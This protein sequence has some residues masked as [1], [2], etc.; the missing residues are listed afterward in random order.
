[1]AVDQSSRS[2]ELEQFYERIEA[3]SLDALWRHHGPGAPSESDACAPYAAHFWRWSDI[4][5]FMQRAGELIA[6]SHED[7]R[8]ALRLVHPS[9]GG[10]RGSATH[11][12]SAA[13]QMVLPGEVAPAHRHTMAAIRFIIKGEGTVTFVDGEPCA[14]HPGDLI[15]TPGWTWHAHLNQTGEPMIW[16]DSLDSPLIG[17]LRQ[18][19]YEEY[20]D[21]VHPATR[22]V[23][24]SLDRYGGGHLRPVWERHGAPISPLLS[25]PWE[26]TER[27]LSEMAR[28]GEASPY[29][30]VAFQYTNPATGGHVLPTIGCWI[31]LIR[32]GIQTQAHRHSSASIYHVFRG[33]GA[34]IIDGARLDWEQGDFFALPPYCWHEHLSVG[35]DGAVLFSTNDLP[36]VTA[37]NL[38]REHPYQE[39]GGHQPV[40][41][42]FEER[43]AAVRP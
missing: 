20:P 10:A 2:G 26:Q 28:L 3:K 18:G 25:F 7:Q 14:M 31:Q 41:A 17:A 5:P 21:Q 9:F 42:N 4:G 11:T 33:R 29:D 23:D 12:V 19:L 35:G 34:T 24:H 22:P 43:Y 27:T 32:A 40:V 8:R 36:V 15:L 38:Y 13:V 39:H 37:L 6:P 16:M 30:D 1:V